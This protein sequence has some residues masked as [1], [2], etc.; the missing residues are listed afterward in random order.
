MSNQ[1][2]WRTARDHG[3]EQSPA[4]PAGRPKADP[5]DKRID[6]LQ[7]EVERLRAELG[8]TDGTQIAA[9][10]VTE[11]GVVTV[12]GFLPESWVFGDRKVV[13]V[14]VKVN[15]GSTAVAVA[16]GW[17]RMP[18]DFPARAWRFQRVIAYRAA[19]RGTTTPT[20][21]PSVIVCM[22]CSGCF[23]AIR[24]ES[25]PNWSATRSW[26]SASAS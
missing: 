14:Q 20:P 21:N 5:R 17:H 9:K 16:G 22:P 2:C 15:A 7:A 11:P 24:S 23:R 12:S 4:C 19:A 10:T 25:I 18:R 1:N 8:K 3:P 13:E 26:T 6:A